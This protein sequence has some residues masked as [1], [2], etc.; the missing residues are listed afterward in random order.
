MRPIAKPFLTAAIIL[1]GLLLAFTLL[2]NVWLRLPSTQGRLQDVV[3]RSFP[4]LSLGSLYA[5]PWGEIR[6]TGINSRPKEAA[7]RFTAEAVRMRISLGAL[8]SGRISVASCSLDRPFL[9]LPIHPPPTTRQEKFGMKNS[10]AFGLAYAP[11]RVSSPAPAPS[12]P[13][14]S[15]GSG[16]TPPSL[17]FS[18]KGDFSVRNGGFRLMD[19]SS[20]PI[21]TLSGVNLAGNRTGGLLTADKLIVGNTLVF[22]DLKGTL[23]NQD[24]SL[25]FH[26]LRAVLGGGTVTGTLDC[27]DVFTSLPRYRLEI[28]L[29]DA[30]L[31]RLLADASYPSGPS[32][33]SVSGNLTLEGVAGQGSTMQG[34]GTLV[35]KEA[36]LQP[37]DFLRQIGRILSIEELQLLRIC[38]GK[39]LFRIESGKLLVDDLLLRSDNLMLAAKGPV[40]GTG[41]L[42]LQTRLLFNE[43]LTSRLKGILGSQLAPAEES[44]YT[45]V[46][47][48]VTGPALN[49]RTDLLERLTGIRIGGDL[50]GL[51]NLLQGLFGKPSPPQ[52]G[53]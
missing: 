16:R 25:A 33:G 14:I 18:T 1:A 46:A 43:K 10:G 49:P 52:T 38:E 36:S 4:D 13:V 8:L 30:D 21:I 51:G 24:G 37:V 3:T 47:F 19:S 50:G 41:E 27:R 20:R 2:L 40:S 34:E 39:C 5:L 31:N 12:T 7:V 45:Q 53:R 35:L 26:D 42:D 6:I 23:F 22:H 9:S 15:A 44:G 48:H 28:A 17:I 32:K 29:Q 11:P